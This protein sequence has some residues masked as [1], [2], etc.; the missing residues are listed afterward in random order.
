MIKSGQFDLN[1]ITDSTN[2]WQVRRNLKVVFS[3]YSA[4]GEMAYAITNQGIISVD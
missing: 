1:K 3:T 4:K 2:F